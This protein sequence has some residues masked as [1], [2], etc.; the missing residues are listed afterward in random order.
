MLVFSKAPVCIL[1]KDI[2]NR[3]EIPHL[4]K[5]FYRKRIVR[6]AVIQGLGRLNSEAIKILTPLL[7]YRR[8]VDM[9]L[10]CISFAYS[11]IQFVFYA[12]YV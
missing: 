8:F 11:N 6:T 12:S 9:V 3:Q 5:K 10:T 1:L 7:P 4:L 2:K